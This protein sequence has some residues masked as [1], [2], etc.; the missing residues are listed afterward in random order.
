MIREVR[1]PAGSNFSG[2]SST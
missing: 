2:S 1:Y